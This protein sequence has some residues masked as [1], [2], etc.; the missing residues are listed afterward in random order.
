MT[1]KVKV[2]DILKSNKSISRTNAENYWQDTRNN[3]LGRYLM[4]TLL[5]RFGI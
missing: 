4:F 1:A 2:Y 3:T 5:Y